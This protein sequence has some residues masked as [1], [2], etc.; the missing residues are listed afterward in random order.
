MV[1]DK[2]VADFFSHN[3]D[4]QREEAER[5]ERLKKDV[6]CLSSDDESKKTDDDLPQTTRKKE[7]TSQSKAWEP[8]RRAEA[9]QRANSV[10][11]HIVCAKFALN[12]IFSS[13]EAAHPRLYR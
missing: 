9:S 12:S 6:I 10:F 4:A 8:W 7:T 5:L 1:S 3:V 11:S 13:K 2:A